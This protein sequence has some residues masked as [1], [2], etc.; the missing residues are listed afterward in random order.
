MLRPCAMGKLSEFVNKG[1]RLIVVDPNA[2]PALEADPE[3]EP[4]PPAPSRSRVPSPPPIPPA[5]APG[6]TPMGRARGR[7]VSPEVAEAAPPNRV[8]RS[9][10]ASDVAD[11]TLL[12]EV[13]RELGIHCRGGYQCQQSGR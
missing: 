12:R 10:V 13:Q 4:E 7:Q 1:V 3:P 5:A 6:P 9:E 8:A 2:E 11:F